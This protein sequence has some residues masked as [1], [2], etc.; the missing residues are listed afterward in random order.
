MWKMDLQTVIANKI[1]SKKKSVKHF[2]TVKVVLAI[3]NLNE[4]QN[5]TFLK[6]KMNNVEVKFQLDTGSDIIINEKL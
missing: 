2:K 4:D 3:Q 1:K 6:V 5:I